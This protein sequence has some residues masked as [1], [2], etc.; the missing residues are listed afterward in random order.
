MIEM[1][2]NVNFS[3]S[4]GFTFCKAVN[5]FSFSKMFS[6][7]FCEELTLHAV[8]STSLK[9][10][11]SATNLAGYA[12]RFSVF[13]NPNS[14]KVLRLLSRKSN[15]LLFN[16]FLHKLDKNFPA[17]SQLLLVRFRNT[18]S[19]KEI[20]Q[21]IINLVIQILAAYYVNSTEVHLSSVA[22][23]GHQMTMV[24]FR[25]KFRSEIFIK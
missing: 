24:Q 17:P 13:Q 2:M 22:T 21:L 19:T 9:I 14:V 7:A 23:D 1:A 12:V 4:S 18:S 20:L 8:F 25:N 6:T 15:E 16:H 3:P 5:W 11:K 10:S